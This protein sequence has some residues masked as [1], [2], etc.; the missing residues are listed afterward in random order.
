MGLKLVKPLLLIDVDGPLNPWRLGPNNF[1]L[2]KDYIGYDIEFPGHKPLLV[3]LNPKHG[4]WFLRLQNRY[5]LIW[6]TAW[7]DH[8]NTLIGPKIGLPDLPVIPLPT[9]WPYSGYKGSWKTH[10]IANWVIDNRPG[11]RFAWVDDEVNRYDRKL[12]ENLGMDTLLLRIE[13]HIGLVDKD[14]QILDQWSRDV[15][16]ITVD[17]K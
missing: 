4:E 12:F 8:A 7:M 9:E 11:A 17:N 16:Q 2:F 1:D 6:A 13:P 14:F 15:S 3:K 5:E 10:T